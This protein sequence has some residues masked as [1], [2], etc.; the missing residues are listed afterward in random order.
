MTKEI[1]YAIAIDDRGN[2]VHV[3]DAEKGR[4]YYCPSCKGEFI[5]RKSGNTGKGSKR[6]HFAHNELTPNCTAESALHY[7]FKKNL[8]DLLNKYISEKKEFIINWNCTA[9][10]E[11]NKGNLLAKAASIREEYNLKV[12]QPD[13]ALLNTEENVI[14]V[15]EIVVTHKPE[16]KV[17]QYYED[18][19]IILIQI[20][21]S[22][23]EDLK[24]I[25]RK[26]STPDVVD[27]CLSPKCPNNKRYSIHRRILSYRDNCGRCFRPIERYSIEVNS[28]F[29]IQRTLDFTDNEINIVKSKRNNIKVKTNPSTNKKYPTSICH[30]CR[31]LRSRNRRNR[32]F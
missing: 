9:C 29:G 24:N 10:S 18:N 21:L 26:I 16:E 28:A 25:E 6:P 1:L 14:A 31:V 2:L 13:I 3:N 12:C 17:L 22:S 32:R 27:Y 11:Y 30:Y 15:I 23:N 4:A 5:L 20:N 19:E 8:T 7:S